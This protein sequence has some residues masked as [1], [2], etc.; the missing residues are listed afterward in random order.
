MGVLPS[1]P[2]H[3]VVKVVDQDKNGQGGGAH[4]VNAT[5]TH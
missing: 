3:E 5:Q 1:F 2:R 4:D